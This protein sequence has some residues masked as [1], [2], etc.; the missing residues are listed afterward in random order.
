[1]LWA[2]FL[3]FLMLHPLLILVIG[4]VRD[5]ELSRLIVLHAKLVFSFLSAA[6]YFKMF[7]LVGAV[8]SRTKVGQKFANAQVNHHLTSINKWCFKACIPIERPY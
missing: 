8:V 7:G 3:Y 4:L 2:Q 5:V 6:K 1:M